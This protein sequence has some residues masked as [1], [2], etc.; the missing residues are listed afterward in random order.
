MGR[1]HSEDVAD[2]AGSADTLVPASLSTRVAGAV[3]DLH[4]FTVVDGAGHNDALWYGPSMA[5]VLD[6]LTDARLP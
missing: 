1:P 4:A 3:P 6:D 2:R 5:D